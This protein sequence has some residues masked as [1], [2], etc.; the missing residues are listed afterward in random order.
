MFFKMKMSERIFDVLI[1]VLVLI[2]FSWL[3]ILLW[4]ISLI[5][6]KKNGFFFQPRVGANKEVFLIIKIRSLQDENDSKLTKFSTFIRK[7]KLDELPQFFNVLLGQ[8]TIVGPRPELE[9]YFIKNKYP[10]DLLK[11]KPGITG[12]ASIYFINETIIKNKCGN[13]DSFE[14]WMFSRKNKLNMIYLKNKGF[15]FNLKIIYITIKRVI[16]N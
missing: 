10:N 13:L 16:F 6:F 7:Y 8:M 12:L 1:S 15:C 3:I 9:S 14:S 2:T 4:L 5:Y 11:L